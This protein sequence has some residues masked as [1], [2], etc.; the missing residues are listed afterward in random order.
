MTCTEC[1]HWSLKR[2]GKMAQSH[3]G[4]CDKRKPWQFF[5]P[6]HTCAKHAAA[7]APIVAA[8]VKW[9]ARKGAA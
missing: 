3:Y 4:L 6:T 7:D 9:L 8:R 1:T 2:A 5:S